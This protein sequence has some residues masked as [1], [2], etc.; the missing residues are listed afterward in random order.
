VSGDLPENW[1][2]LSLGALWD[3]LNDPARF[4]TPQSTVEAVLYCV[5]A[6]GLKA[7]EEPANL[8]RLRRCDQAARD[9]IDR[10]IA[11]MIKKSVIRH[12][13]TF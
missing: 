7:L 4:A 11:D 1:H 2:E 6:R 5:R 8:E 10:R 12:E 9:E 3:R 13:P